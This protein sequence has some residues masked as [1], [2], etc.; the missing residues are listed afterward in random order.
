MTD[1]LYQDQSLFIRELLQNGLDALRHLNALYKT[2]S[3]D[4]GDLLVELSHKQDAE[5]YHIVTCTDNGVGM[6]S[7]IVRLFLTR[8]G[9]S[10]YRS[11]QF[12][13][14]RIRFRE[15]GC[16][17]DPCAR[18]GIG[19]ISCFMISDEVTI[20]TRKDF[21]PGK[22][23]GPPLVIEITGLSGIIVVRSGNQEQPTG[24]TV[25][26][27]SRK[28]NRVF[29]RWDD[30]MQLIDV[31]QSYAVATEYPIK[32]TAE[33][34][35]D[36][37]DCEIPTSTTIVPHQLEKH[38]LTQ[39]L[40]TIERSFQE[41]DDRLGGLLRYAC[42]TDDKDMPSVSNKDVYW[43]PPIEKSGGSSSSDR[44]VTLHRTSDDS[45]LPLDH[46][47]I[48]SGQFSCD[49][50]LISGRRGRTLQKPSLNGTNWNLGQGFGRIVFNLDAR[51]NLKPEL[52]PARSPPKNSFDE[53]SSWINVF[54][55]AGKAFGLLLDD[56]ALA[57]AK[58]ND[59]ARFWQLVEIDNLVITHLLSK[60]CYEHL[61][62]PFADNGKTSWYSIPELPALHLKQDGNDLALLNADGS[63]LDIP[64]SVS[65]W[66]PADHGWIT[67][68]RL[69]KLISMCCEITLSDNKIYLHTISSLSDNTNLTDLTLGHRYDRV[70]LARFCS[71]LSDYFCISGFQ[72]FLNKSHR[73][74]QRAKSADEIGWRDKSP[75]DQFLS[76]LLHG[77]VAHGPIESQ[78][79]EQKRNW[80]L[81]R[82]GQLYLVANW[83]D[84]AITPLPYQYLD[85]AGVKYEISAELLQSLA[86]LPQQA[87]E[88]DDDD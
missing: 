23:A 59:P 5:G 61:T 10:Y 86:D 24:T 49:G 47:G 81:R 66:A 18:F 31:V 84:P 22:Q 1:S 48:E 68:N 54:N 74:V 60:T 42:L 43:R 40:Y 73:L 52:T 56:L 45:E 83:D 20:L 39:H 41:A 50:I 35:G 78:L 14:E 32:A 11:P 85:Y 8:A 72:G 15:H 55:F 36:V 9:R 7:S 76:M 16:D 57:C 62:F 58:G 2:E 25:Q 46:Y 6:D 79:S 34:N 44:K 80:W 30:P 21:G 67:K 19:F 75:Y 28:A 65:E 13:Q 53:P 77:L 82:V 26:V 33:L 63:V 3:K 64:T 38:G 17:F 12:E 27:K 29:D 87:E 4:A 70:S 37:R 88:E 51:S 69:I 71:S